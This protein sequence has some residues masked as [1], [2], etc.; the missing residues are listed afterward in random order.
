MKRW[1]ACKFTCKLFVALYSFSGG[2]DR[3]KFYRINEP[4][5]MPVSLE[6]L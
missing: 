1:L 3:I 6:K 5:A 2:Y 4:P